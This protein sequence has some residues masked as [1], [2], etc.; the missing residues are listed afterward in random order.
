MISPIELDGGIELRAIARGDGAALA[1]A[2]E[3][4]RA[5]LAP[6]E[7]ERTPEFFSA[8]VQERE[9]GASLRRLAEGTAIPLVLAEPAGRIVG[10]VN[11]SE[12]VRGVFLNAHLGYW[13]DAELQG[14][15]LATA[16]VG[17]ALHFARRAGLHRVQAGTLVHNSASQTVLERNGFTR[18]GLAPRYLRI[19]GDWRDHVL[20]Q[21]LLED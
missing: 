13:I 10:R 16:A 12:V 7:P 15:G 9:V 8:T 6:W 3:R 14:R 2:Y 18:I 17:G 11:L 19:A 21:R 4:N 20:F 5:H 1:A